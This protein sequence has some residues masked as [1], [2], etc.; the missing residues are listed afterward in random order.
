MS[1]NAPDANS[2]KQHHVD[3]DSLHIL[4]L[5][6][7][8][9]ETPVLKSARLIK[10]SRLVSVIEFFDSVQTG[11]GQVDVEGLHGICSWSETQ[12]LPDLALL[13]R[14]AR[15]PSY[16]I[17]S[18]RI[19]LRELEITVNDIAALKLSDSKIVELT[20]Y[21]TAFTHPLISQIYG[22]DDVAIKNFDDI[23]TLFKDPDVEKARDKL[24]VMAKAL[25]I[26]LAEIPKF[27]EDYGDVFMSLS[28]Y[29]RCLDEI[30]PSIES[31]I[32]SL[33]DIRSNWQLRQDQSLMKACDLVETSFNNLS[34]GISGRF[35][36]FDRSTK[37]MWNDISAERFRQVENL[38]TR[39]H[40]TIGGALCALTV[41]MA[42]WQKLFPNP[43][44]GGPVRRAEF[45][46]SDIK[47]GIESIMKIEDNAP[48][49]ARLKE[50]DDIPNEG[51]AETEEETTK[52]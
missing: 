46:M 50:S 17:Y 34:A 22:G 31:L 15:L 33:Y 28:Y 12:P 36:N 3:M 9:I 8:P 7:L 24:R 10:N 26:T 6:I 18:L 43:D 16:D 37:E 5:S 35:E 29:R 40:I 48:M 23:V 39:Y 2:D 4:P 11:S 19:A 42:A 25:G 38:I 13:R 45:I 51:G 1:S 27:L 52:E 21:M 20:D 41:K 44:I 32:N 49:L 30:Q 47:T 14:L